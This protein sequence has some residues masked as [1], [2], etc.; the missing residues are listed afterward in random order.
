MCSLLRAWR[1]GGRDR[2]DP[3]IGRSLDAGAGSRHDEGVDRTQLADFLRIRRARIQPADVGLPAGTYR[4]TPGLRREEVAAMAGISVDYYTRLEQARGPRPSTQVLTSLARALR[5]ANTDRDH[6]FQ[7]VGYQTAFSGPR[8]DV[9]AGLLQLIER[10]DDTP[11]FV[12]D[13]IY[14]LVGWNRMAVALLSDPTDWAVPDRNLI[15]QLFR[16]PYTDFSEPQV[17]TFAVQCVAD[18][19]TAA[20]RYPGDPGIAELLARLQ[21]SDEFVRRWKEYPVLPPRTTSTKRIP[22]PVVGELEL[23]CEVLD[24]TARDQRLVLYTAAPGTRSA[25]AL[26]MLRSTLDA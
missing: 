1:A 9:P 24:I 6:L 10:L 25:D 23:D 26:A 19:R 20:S 13:A 21:S 22:H 2:D 12:L 11:A 5:M 7:L 8:Q 4:R 16:S 17:L 3:G 14:N 15:W 18:L